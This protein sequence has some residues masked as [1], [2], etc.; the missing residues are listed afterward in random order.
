[1]DA[2]PTALPLV[3]DGQARALAVTS[4]RRSPLMP[5]L[6]AV[7]ETLPGFETASWL[8]VG[9]P[10]G[11][12]EEITARMGAAVI[13]AA[14]DPETARRFA[15]LGAEAIGSTRAELATRVAAEDMRW[16]QLV[17]ARG[18]TAE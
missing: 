10:A 8:A 1:V 6:P 9:S 3:R 11:V 17:R 2:F 4:A 14:H 18:I 12:P 7:A 15:A 13:A 16:G 5:E